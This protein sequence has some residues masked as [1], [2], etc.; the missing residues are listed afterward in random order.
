MTGG[1]INDSVSNV[2]ESNRRK[3]SGALS[4]T[5][6]RSTHNVLENEEYNF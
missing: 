4:S 5:G 3:I 2:T 1:N 6:R